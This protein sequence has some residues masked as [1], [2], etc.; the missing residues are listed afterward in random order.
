MVEFT[1]PDINTY[2]NAAD[3]QSKL[4]LEQ[5]KRN[6]LT[7]AGQSMS[8]NNYS[9]AKNQLFQAGM[10]DQGLEI[11]KLQRQRA[12]DAAQASQAAE[13]R[14]YKLKQ[15]EME[16]QRAGLERMGQMLTAV[17]TP[18]Q[19]EAIKNQ[20]KAQGVNIPPQFESFANKDAALR[21]VL[22]LKD[23]LD[24]QYK[25]DALAQK[26]S[27][28]GEYSKQ[29]TYGIDAEG[30]PVLLQL[31][32]TGKAVRS[33]LPEGVVKVDPRLQMLDTG[34]GFAPVSKVTGKPTGPE[35]QKNTAQAEAQKVVGKGQG[36][37]IVDLPAVE[38][39]A[40][41]LFGQL[42]NVMSDPN[43]KNV[44]GVEAYLPTLLPKN[45][46]TEEK[47]KQLTS[48]AFVQSFKDLKG[49]GAITEI[50]GKKA[51]SALAR[52]ENLRQDDAGYVEALNDFKRE[53]V[54]LVALAKRKAGAKGNAGSQGAQQVQQ[55]SQFEGF[56]IQ[57][58]D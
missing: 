11:D 15:R 30:N 1:F 57:R 52:L 3:T 25:Q 26:I 14:A 18:E 23:Q 2:Y 53:V 10:L 46:T 16:T 13:D 55:P 12:S 31:S 20:F 50:E 58:I 19:Y 37:A 34:T 21:T 35:I 33:E 44:T 42:D 17:Q 29:P 56:T 43:L 51:T 6:A 49:G 39:A 48:G 32:P 9:G 47:A 4:D 41:R 24:L 27:G 38:G 8:Q 45:V 36:D 28:A 40:Q 7:Q 22:S 5:A 54:A